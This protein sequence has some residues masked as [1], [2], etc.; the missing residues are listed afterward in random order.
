M[1]KTLIEKI[2]ELITEGFELRGRR[3]ADQVLEGANITKE[4]GQPYSHM[5]TLPP[6]L[7]MVLVYDRGQPVYL[8][9]GK[10]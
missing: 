9:Y 2:F 5:D 7:A 6:E 4:N 1:G 3:P 10:K 8:V